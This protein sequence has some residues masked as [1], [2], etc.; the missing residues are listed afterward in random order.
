M[1]ISFV[2]FAIAYIGFQAEVQQ[3]MA[4]GGLINNVLEPVLEPVGDLVDGVTTFKYCWFD[5]SADATLTT[6]NTCMNDCCGVGEPSS[7]ITECNS[8]LLSLFGL[9]VDLDLSASAC[10]TAHADKNPTYQTI[11]VEGG[12][13]TEMSSCRS[14]D[15]E[16]GAMGDPHVKVGL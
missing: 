7:K 12:L 2:S 8:G 14:P 11:K 4:L 15:D 1:K 13:I 10:F 9:N 3:T 6:P 5:A 16:V